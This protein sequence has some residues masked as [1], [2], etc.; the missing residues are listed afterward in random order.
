MSEK[1]ILACDSTN[2]YVRSRF[3]DFFIRGMVPLEH[4]W[5][6]RDNSKCTSLKFAVEWGNNHT[7]KVLSY[8]YSHSSFYQQKIVYIDIT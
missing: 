6:I 4:Y 5:P 2:L 8:S 3:H 7:D 1:Y